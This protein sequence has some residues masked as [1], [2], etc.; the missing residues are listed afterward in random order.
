MKRIVK[1]VLGID[2]AQKELVVSLGRME[3]DLAIECYASKVFLNTKSGFIELVKWVNKLTEPSIPVRY[4]MEATGVYHEA[5]AYYL[6]DQGHEI[7]IVLPSR[8]SNYFRTLEVKTITDKTASE[9]ILRFGLER[10]LDAWKKPNPTFKKLRQI[11]RER[12]Q[13]IGERTLIKNQLHAEMAESEPN[14]S[15]IKRLKKRLQLL[16]AQEKEINKEITALTKSNEDIKKSIEV[17]QSIPGVGLITA[18][19]ILAE[20]NGFELIRNKKQLVS[21]AGLDVQEKQSGTSVRGKPR[22]SKKGNRYLRKA[23]HFP[24]LAA[25]RHE[26]RFKDIFNN[27]VSKHGI[28]MKAI[29]AV[30]RKVLE[31][32][33]TLHKTN[34]VFDS[35]YTM[36]LKRKNSNQIDDNCSSEAGSKPPYCKIKQL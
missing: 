7:S 16:N 24:A 35:N 32:V 11:T 19:T 31:L 13:L 5:L 2:V 23:V 21:Y 30:Q 18:A 14:S 28:K 34:R 27:L 29:V 4:V 15:S 9:A 20:T 26:K 25:I 3:F 36:A 8:I 1:Q 10:K 22:I 17:A 33:Y 12:D 6:T